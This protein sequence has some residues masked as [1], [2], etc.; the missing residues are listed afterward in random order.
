MIE[1]INKKTYDPNLY[2]SSLESS[3]YGRVS[4]RH[5]NDKNNEQK[6]SR[7]AKR[8]NYSLAGM[9]AQI[10]N[11]RNNETDNDSYDDVENQATEAKNNSYNL[12]NVLS[13][14]RRFLEL[15]TENYSDIKY[16]PQLLSALTGLSRDQIDNKTSLTLGN[17]RDGT[18]I[19]NS[20]FTIL[21]S[22]SNERG[23]IS[24]SKRLIAKK[25]DI[26]KNLHLL[27][28][29]TK[30]STLFLTNTTKSDTLSVN[31]D[32]NRKKRKNTRGPGINNSK[33]S[34]SLKRILIS[35]RTLYSYLDGLDRLNFKIICSN[36]YNKKYFK[37]LSL[38]H[39]CSI[40]GDNNN[41]SQCKLCQTK[42]CSKLKCYELHME[43]RCGR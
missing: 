5:S 6:N 36:V 4:K 27:Y 35:K 39:I 33:S 14:N 32:N 25:Y 3:N 15:D 18:T 2:F 30:P 7:Q 37:V 21:N 31:V 28:N 22:N 11:K 26:P 40:C 1:E 9:E 20:N 24:E 8:I 29:C 10:Y 43:T 38:M 16:V 12:Q 13:S 19:H 17:G 34:P 42:I 41:L 23:G